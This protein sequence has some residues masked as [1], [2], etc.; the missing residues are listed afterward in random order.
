MVDATP[1]TIM[2]RAL[3]GIVHEA[4]ADNPYGRVAMLSDPTGGIFSVITLAS[5]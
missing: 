4:S 3:G 2:A 1:P 5:S